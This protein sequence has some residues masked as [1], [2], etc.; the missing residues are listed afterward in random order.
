MAII[1]NLR[2]SQEAIEAAISNFEAR[3]TA[4]ENSYL[5]ISNEVRTLDGTWH[6]EASEKFKAQ[7]DTLYGNLKQNETVMSNVIS[8]LKTALSIYQEQ[9][10]KASA[11]INSL[12]EGTIYKGV[13]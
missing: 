4:L 5:K 6:G 1:D 12:E 7:F 11:L 2:V 10:A 9:E 8:N 3:K 13:L